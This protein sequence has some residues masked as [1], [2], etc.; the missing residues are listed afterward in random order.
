MSTSDEIAATNQIIS[1]VNQIIDNWKSQLS[2]SKYG[3]A[4][5]SKPYSI[6]CYESWLNHSYFGEMNYLAEHLKYKK[7]P[8]LLSELIKQQP[9]RVLRS[10]I[11][12]TFPYKPH[13]KNPPPLK[14][15]KI[16]SY[17]GGE[18]YHG[19]LKGQ[20]EAIAG[21]LRDYFPEH[22]FLVAT[23]SFPVL[24]RDLAARAGLGWMGKNTCLIDR[25]DGSFFLLG[26]ILTD[27]AFNQ[28]A[29]LIHDFCGTCNKCIQACPTQAL[30]KPRLLDATRC[31]SYLTIESQKIPSPSL[32][33]GIGEWFFG[34]DICQDVCPWNEKLSRQGKSLNPSSIDSTESPGNTSEREQ[35]IAELRFILTTSGKKLT[36]YFKS[37]A[38]SRARPRG[39][40][41][42]ALIVI[43]NLKLHELQP[44]VENFRGDPFF[45]ELVDWCLD[46]LKSVD[47][48][49]D[50]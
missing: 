43:G 49:A 6:S 32:R 22:L 38:L 36:K 13:P 41:R 28:P 26:E 46:A 4:D 21:D 33:S 12:F 45:S 30:V 18:D 7:N 17:V 14:G 34:C 1:K 9:S 37:S 44:E 40:K 50:P 31:I 27:I 47:T 8:H 23:D 15:L 2:Y 39:L 19:W 48:Y 29:N 20:L 25:T 5:L 3:W 24:E 35:K 10:G 42:N 16:A 11:A